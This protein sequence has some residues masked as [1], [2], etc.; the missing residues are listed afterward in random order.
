MPTPTHRASAGPRRADQ[1][2]RPR[3]I[4]PVHGR[5]RVET[6]HAPSS[7]QRTVDN[8]ASS[9]NARDRRSGG[10]VTSGSATLP[11]VQRSWQRLA[12]PNLLPHISPS[13]LRRTHPRFSPR[14]TRR[15]RHERVVV[16]FR[17]QVPVP[18][19]AGQ[20]LKQHAGRGRLHLVPHIRRPVRDA[21]PTQDLQ[22][23]RPSPPARR[24]SLVQ[25][26]VEDNG[27]L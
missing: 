12:A 6:P 10:D 11:A 14:Y 16:D 25:S 19:M 21:R 24:L 22:P 26:I 4:R 18:G 23:T 17:G 1:R 15:H 9:T 13:W 20:G 5:D 2:V 7:H 8:A 3:R 27:P